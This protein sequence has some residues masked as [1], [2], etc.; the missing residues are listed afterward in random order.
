MCAFYTKDIE[1]FNDKL[2]FLP[3]A[4]DGKSCIL[5]LKDAD[6]NWRQMEWWAFYFEFKAKQLLE[7]YFQFPGDKFDNVVFD[8]K[9]HINWDL[10]ASAIK[11]HLHKIILNDINAMEQAIEKYG[12]HGEII[13]LCDVEYND[14]DRSFQKWHTELKGGMSQ[15]EKERKKRTS[16]SR[17]RKTQAVLTEIIF[18]VIKAD[19]LEILDIMRQGRNSNGMPRKEKYVL[20]LERI[21]YFETHILEI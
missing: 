9:G 20:D 3:V 21:N 1:I 13:A 6:Y 8:L 14:K 15:Y 18:L 17:Y 16:I 2:K 4:W 7:K 19:N 12:Y 11:S 5:E 10:K